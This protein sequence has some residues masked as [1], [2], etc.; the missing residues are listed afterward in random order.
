M[1]HERRRSR[2]GFTI[3]EVLV[4]LAVVAASLAAIGAVVATTARATRSLEQRVALIQTARAV[5]TGLPRRDQLAPGQIGGEIGG[6]RWRI[7][8]SPLAAGGLVEDSPWVPQA[9]VIRVQSPS[10]ALLELNTVRL[11]R[12]AKE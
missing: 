2:A 8:V 7:N 4:A 10:G 6:H 9:I 1:A 3:I 12:R 5:E 11:S